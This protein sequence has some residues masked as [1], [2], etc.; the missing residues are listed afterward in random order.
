MQA[1][2]IGKARQVS[3][4][5]PSVYWLLPACTRVICIEI[6]ST[7]VTAKTKRI[8]VLIVYLTSPCTLDIYVH[9]Y[10]YTVVITPYKNS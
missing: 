6:P 8:V 1:Y 2:F 4:P 5:E 9:V 10:I 3:D 7:K